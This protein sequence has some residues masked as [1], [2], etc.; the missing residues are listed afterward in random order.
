MHM[1]KI[2]NLSFIKTKTFKVNRLD[3]MNE[4]ILIWRKVECM[5]TILNDSTSHNSFQTWIWDHILLWFCFYLFVWQTFTSI[6][7]LVLQEDVSYKNT[8]MVLDT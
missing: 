5:I 2:T 3:N 4:T 1:L 7:S 6:C 8:W